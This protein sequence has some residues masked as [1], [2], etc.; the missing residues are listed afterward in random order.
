MESGDPEIRRR[1]GKTWD[2]DNLRALVA[3]L[4]SAGFGLSL[5]TLVGAGGSEAG[6]NHAAKTARLVHSL[7]LARGDMVFLLDENEVRDPAASASRFR[8][9]DR[10]RLDPAARTDE[11][12]PGAAS[13]ARRQGPSLQPGETM[14][15]SER[16][17]TIGE[18]SLE[19]MVR[20]VE[21]VRDRLL[22]RPKRWKTR[23][24]PT[25]L[26]EAMPSR[27][28]WRGLTKRL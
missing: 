7:D 27:P 2:D 4:K 14:D 24:F 13:R 16:Q 21:K 18:V 15:L 5:L 1:Y 23:T 12:I 3:D 10:F 26:R 8:S 11:A 28:G 22:H 9:P 25:P 17:I 6:D 19:R 20:A